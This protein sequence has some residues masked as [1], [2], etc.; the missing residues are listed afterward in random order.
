M[1]RH[2]RMICLVSA[3]LITAGC[4]TLTTDLSDP[5]LN[6]A[7]VTPPG[8]YA[9]AADVVAENRDNL[10]LLLPST[11]PAFQSLRSAAEA[12]APT[13]AI[14]LARI[15][16]AKAQA[17]RAGANRLPTIGM[18]AGVTTS[19]TNPAAFGGNLPAGISIDRNQTSYGGN[20]TA[21]WDADIFG[22]LRASAR[23]A[24]LQLN[25]ATADAA[26]VRLSLIAAIAANVVDWRTLQ[27]RA[28]VLEEDLAAAQNLTQL[29]G[30]RAKAGISPG[31]DQVQAESLVAD[32]R[33]RL[34]ALPGERAIL[35]GNLVTLTGSDAQTVIASLAPKA[36]TV[37]RPR[38]PAA[39][40]SDLLRA[41][42]D[43]A[44]AEARLAAADANIAA[45]AAERYPKLTL[46]DAL[47]L[48]SFAL[49]DLFSSDA[50]IGSLGA[51]IA[52]P[53]IDFGRVETQIDESKANARQ[54]FAAY[55]DAVFTALGEAETA[56]GQ[57][58]SIDL[59]GQAL[60]RQRE[61]DRDAEYL[62]AIRYRNGL[63]DFRDVLN[64]RRVLNN[65][66]TQVAIA[67]GRAL[68]AR[69]ALWQ[70]LGGS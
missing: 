18:D 36:T 53:L 31:L 65:T 57:L 44:A 11:D 55:R 24:Q 17:R 25:A 45:A 35:I 37:A 56:Y 50:V 10:D 13:L 7:Q 2:F 52:G 66:R 43:V 14:A 29:T 26:A 49:G 34:A 58:G 40:P 27:N 68:R 16:A 33:S 47:G 62:L 12:N 38:P 21:N 8:A 39:A 42:P 63:S 28:A 9:L 30:S 60:R 48:L 3:S 64:S 41:R 46:S 59:E 15:D 67:E 22:G 23:A 51:T 61:F 19:R 70:A 4:S 54:A 1:T 69:I 6:P 20:I 5:H 32:V